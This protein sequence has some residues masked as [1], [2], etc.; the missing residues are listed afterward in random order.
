MPN[1]TNFGTIRKSLTF[2]EVHVRA[3]EVRTH[4]ELLKA[5]STSIQ[6]LEICQQIYIENRSIL[7]LQPEIRVY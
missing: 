2:V 4:V 1:H 7:I 5:E 6:N 3:Q